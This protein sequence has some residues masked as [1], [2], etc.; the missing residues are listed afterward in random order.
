V[1]LEQKAALEQRKAD[2][3]I[4][5][6]QK[7][8]AVKEKLFDIETQQM[9]LDERLALERLGY[10]ADEISARV[11]EL[12]GQRA[13]IARMN[14]EATD[15]A[16]Q[17]ARENAANRA[18]EIVR[19]H[20]R[21]VFE[22]LKQQAG[23]V[24]DALLTKSQSVWQSIANSFKTAVL[25]AIKEIVTS[26]VAAA[27]MALFG[28][29]RASFAAGGGA[30]GGGG[31]LG[32]LGGLLGAGAG[33][34]G[35][36]G[37][38]ASGGGMIFSA[39]GG[40]PS[41]A[42]GGGGL[43]GGLLGGKGG[44]GASLAGLK[45]F[46]GFGG[47]VQYA[48][49]QATTWAAS[50]FGQKLSALGRSNAALLGGGLLAFDGLRRGGLLGMGETTAGGAMIGF[51]YGGPVGA[52]IGG[53]VGLAAGIGRLFIHGA[54]EKAREKIKSLYGVNVTDKG[55][56]NQIV[57]MVKEGFG[58]NFDVGLRSPQV[59]E[60]V[61]LYAMTT[62]QPAKGMPATMQSLTM[63]ETGGSLYSMPNY[64][65]GVAQGG[66]TALD[67]I[68]RGAASGASGVTIQLDGP[69]TTALLRGEAVSAIQTNTRKVASA[70]VSAMKSNASR[71][72]LTTLQLSPGL[73]T[74]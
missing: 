7:V 48:P 35:L 2:I 68:G 51:K 27:L 21:Q 17:A 34:G 1:T 15:S 36:F 46:L 43:L 33:G 45:D 6:I 9:V 56:L 74:N 52:L 73:I 25:T 38:G 62:G 67:T 10:R 24:F 61:Q 54:T 59:R 4:E 55:V 50:T 32:G 66:I 44:S 70:T 58:G 19:D 40:G 37:S 63:S 57:Q 14:D 26:R 28:G 39:A 8:H 47:G 18:A 12:Q 11:A 71:R 16:V 72:Q 42:G 30:G 41:G 5:Y 49:G 23:G 22:S 69:A 53:A 60:L 64:Q 65:N 3:E 13:E 20:N 31:L 29:G